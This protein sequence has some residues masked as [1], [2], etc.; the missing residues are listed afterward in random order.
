MSCNRCANQATAT[1]AAAGVSPRQTQATW[2]MVYQHLPR[3]QGCGRFLSPRNPQ[4]HYTH[5]RMRG[6]AQGYPGR[7][8][9][10]LVA[11]TT[12]RERVGRAITETDVLE[13][14]IR[15]NP[16]ALAG[17]VLAGQIADRDTIDRLATDPELG[18]PLR[19]WFVPR[20]SQPVARQI[21]T[22]ADETEGMRYTAILHLDDRETLDGLLQNASPRL[23][24][25]ITTRLEV[26]DVHRAAQAARN[27][28]GRRTPPR[29]DRCGAFLPRSGEC[30]NPRCPTHR[31]A[32]A[33]A[34][35]AAPGT[36][37]VRAQPAADPDAQYWSDLL[38]YGATRRVNQWSATRRR[39]EVLELAFDA[40]E[41]GVVEVRSPS[42][43]TYRVERG[44]GCNCPQYRF[45]RHQG[46]CRHMDAV[47]TAMR[48]LGAEALRWWQ[49]DAAP[50]QARADDPP[51]ADIPTYAHQ[52]EPGSE[53]AAWTA[54]REAEAAVNDAREQQEMDE[55]LAVYRRLADS[56]E[57]PASLRDAEVWAAAREQVRQTPYEY[58]RENVLNGA[59][60]TFGLEIECVPNNARDRG[61]AQRVVDRLR[62]EG[63]TT[64]TRRANY[65][66][67]AQHGGGHVWGIER[68]GSLGENGIEVIS[69]V[70]SDDPEHWRQLER[71][72][73]IIRDEGGTVDQRC[74]GHVHVGVERTLDTDP[75]RWRRL[76]RM[77]GAFQDVIYR[78]SARGRQHRG[79]GSGYEYAPPLAGREQLRPRFG[80]MD[81]VHHFRRSAGRAGL[82]YQH[83][84]DHRVEFRQFDGSV[85]AARIQQNVR[86]AVGMVMGSSETIPVRR[87]PDPQRV[88]QHRERGNG[89]DG[90]V[91]S[92]L[93]LVFRRGRTTDKL[94]ALRLYE[95]GAWQP[96]A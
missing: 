89:D 50:S 81:D 44:G 41:V 30:R 16:D 71:V 93:D 40:G 86:L 70:L 65:H 23:R 45:R 72:C 55:A 66:C 22:A 56:G 64:Q 61:F 1:M 35:T 20:A 3:C 79:A 58:E 19:S 91:R 24:E 63:L 6:Q 59:P 17:M 21:A 95:Q 29:C 57:R 53:A 52:V 14:M 13:R 42:G 60:A 32:V 33:A 51:P 87:L 68:D 37:T 34:P 96:A 94:A 47:E 90:S 83:A 5:C 67:G 27:G 38:T 54:R 80:S 76:A 9:P 75:Q 84:G 46:P 43:R 31:E 18:N 48:D 88:G 7:W 73:Q 8:P 62:T 39:N 15:R 77:Y 74:G 11:F 78:M 28:A 69:P 4:C 10:A 36:A 92:F 26:L 12:R 49:G 85:D 82:N 2:A 25:A